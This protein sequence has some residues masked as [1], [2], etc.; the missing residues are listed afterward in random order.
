RQ[1]LRAG[2]V[3]GD[4]RQVDFGLLRGGKLDLRLFGSLL[5]ALQSQLVVL[6]IDTVVLLELACEVFDEA[7]V[8]V[9]TAEEGVAI[10]GLYLED[11][12]ADFQ[13]GDIEGTAAEVV[14]G[15]RL[16]F[17]LV[18]AVGEGGGSR[19]VDDAQHFEAGN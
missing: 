11:A 5:E 19:L 17:G 8:E 6:Q 16:A 13:N 15:N 18:Q 14:D 2:G 4:E 1:V 12:V 3:R 7:H 9:F 10:G